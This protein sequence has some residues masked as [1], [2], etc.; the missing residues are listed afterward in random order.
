MAYSFSYVKSEGA[1]I[2]MF[3]AEHRSL[4][5]VSA[6]SHQRVYLKPSICHVALFI[7]STILNNIVY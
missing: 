3:G 1:P 6:D 7:H 4:E 5:A 2:R